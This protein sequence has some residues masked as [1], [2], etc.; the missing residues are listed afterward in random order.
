LSTEIAVAISP[1][2]F[3]RGN[4]RAKLNYSKRDL[5]F[6]IGL[7]K[8][9]QLRDAAPMVTAEYIRKRRSSLCGYAKPSSIPGMKI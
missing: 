4:Q 6:S 5:S 3:R 1:P 8:R 7:S 2:F 9:Y